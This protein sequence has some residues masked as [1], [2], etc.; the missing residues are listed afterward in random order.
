MVR[1]ALGRS[2]WLGLLAGFVMAC[3]SAPPAVYMDARKTDLQARE[4]ITYSQNKPI[5][6][7]VFETDA[8]GDTLYRIAFLNGKEHGHALFFYPNHQLREERFF[9]NGWKEGV[10]RGWYENGKPRF[11]Y[12]FHEDQFQGPYKEWLSDGLL[13]RNMNY[14]KG[15]EEGLQQN[16]YMTGKIKANYIIKNGRR[17]GLLGTKNCKNV[18]DSLIRE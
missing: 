10:H 14:E 2:K 3:Q 17:Y 9:E 1:L 18:S 13:F 6:G 16:W 15:Q 8:Q 5:S 11:E 12:H 4:G 7:V